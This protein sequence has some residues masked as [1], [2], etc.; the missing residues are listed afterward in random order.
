MIP[1]KKMSGR[2]GRLRIAIAKTPVEIGRCYEVVR[3]LRPHLASRR[4]FTERVVRQQREGYLLAYLEVDGEVRAVAGYRFLESLFSGRFLYVDDLVTR[5]QDRSLGYGAQLFD[6]LIQQARTHH[7]ENL[8][9]DSGVQRFDAHRFYLINR[10]KIAS[11]H[12]SRAIE[13]D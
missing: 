8:E 3:E 13:Q 10:M 4:K 11:Y 2:S 12:F 5:G 6:W 7:C 1:K 9:L